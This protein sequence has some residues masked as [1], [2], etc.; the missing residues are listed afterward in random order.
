MSGYD[1]YKKALVRLEL[2]KFDQKYYELGL[3]FLNQI[4]DDL[5]LGEIKSLS[6][7]LDFGKEAKEALL[8]GLM[9]LL[10]LNVGNTTQNAL[11]TD[12]YNAKRAK[13]LSSN[14]SVTDV[15]PTAKECV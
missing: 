5:S 11:Y 8:S 7:E 14:E 15:L 3:E 2:Q 12:L 1:I 6:D 4:A 13:F 9:M 10:S